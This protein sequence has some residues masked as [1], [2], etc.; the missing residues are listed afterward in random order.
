MNR[1][2]AIALGA[3]TLAVALGTGSLMQR[4]APSDHP[5][6]SRADGAQTAAPELPHIA[7]AAIVPLA[8]DVGLPHT[9]VTA[10]GLVPEAMELPPGALSAAAD[11]TRSAWLQRG[12]L[13]ALDAAADG[14]RRAADL[15]PRLAELELA[16]EAEPVSDAAPDCGLRLALVAVPPAMIDVAFDAPCHPEARAVLRHAGLAVT[17][18]TSLAGT[19]DLQLPALA[20]LAEVT[21]ALSGGPSVRAE[22]AVPDLAAYDRVVV[23]WQNADAFQLHAFEFGADFGSPGHVSAA[24]PAGPDRALGGVG[25]FLTLL[26]DS[27]PDWPLLAEVYTFPSER[28]ARSGAVELVLEAAITA[29]TCGRE[30]LGETLEMRRG[31]EVTRTEIDVGMPE[32]DAIGGFVL[33]GQL[34]EDLLLA[35]N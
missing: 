5:A 27:R 25:G 17:G 34:F 16:P 12:G 26:G 14:A 19:L 21:V 1:T 29:E 28:M 15:L 4:M 24:S 7:D 10:G 3:A 35:R 2:R 30:L 9:A 32:C 18:Q 8:A 33:L 11:G 13:A 20:A 6:L 22:V 31:G 23:Q